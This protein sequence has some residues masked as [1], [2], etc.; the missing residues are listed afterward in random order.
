MEE[1]T[2]AS[3][4]GIKRETAY[5]SVGEDDSFSVS[6]G[7]LIPRPFAFPQSW[8]RSNLR[9]KRY[10]CGKC[11]Q[12][13]SY[14]GNLARHKKACEGKFDLK[15]SHCDKVFYRPDVLKIHLQAKH[16]VDVSNSS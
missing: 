16:G 1:N 13:F 6:F 3:L 8:Q 12:S 7:S 10:M 15:C 14:T 2:G 4:V 11:N 5:S 9:P